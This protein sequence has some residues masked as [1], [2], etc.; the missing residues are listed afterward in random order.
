M[1]QVMR[2]MDWFVWAL[3]WDVWN[4]VAVPVVFWGAALMALQ[5]FTQPS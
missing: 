2:I 4:A 5:K 3:S 1:T